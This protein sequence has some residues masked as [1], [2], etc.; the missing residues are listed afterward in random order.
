[1]SMPGR[2]VTAQVRGFISRSIRCSLARSIRMRRTTPRLLFQAFCRTL[3]TTSWE[4]MTHLWRT[5]IG[6]WMTTGTQSLSHQS[7]PRVTC[8]SFCFLQ[9][10]KSSGGS[11]PK[12]QALRSQQLSCAFGF[13]FFDS[14]AKKSNFLSKAKVSKKV[15]FCQ[16][17]KPEVWKKVSGQQQQKK[18]QKKGQKKG[19]DKGIKKTHPKNQRHSRHTNNLAECLPLQI[20]GKQGGGPSIRAGVTTEVV[21]DGISWLAQ[22]PSKPRPKIRPCP[23]KVSPPAALIATLPNRHAE[24]KEDRL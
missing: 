3:T 2:H 6:P 10:E 17:P 23:T 18:N 22:A 15:F 11:E 14:L 5:S 4:L 1:M 24:R 19:V 21:R 16:Q 13:V 9:I 12:Q 20:Q 8:Q 7:S